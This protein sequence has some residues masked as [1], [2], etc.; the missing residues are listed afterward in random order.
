MTRSVVKLPHGGRQEIKYKGKL[1]NVA[2]V[3]INL[4]VRQ[5]LNRRI[6]SSD[7]QRSEVA[8]WRAARDQI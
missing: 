4:M 5:C 3:E 8:A 6:D 2:E 1:A 7:T